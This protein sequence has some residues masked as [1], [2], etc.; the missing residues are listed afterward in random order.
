MSTFNP[1]EWVERPLPA[2]SQANNIL[3]DKV[4]NGAETNIFGAYA[5]KLPEIKV[6]NHISKV[7]LIS[8][9]RVR[10]GDN[11]RPLYDLG[12][13]DKSGFLQPISDSRGPNQAATFT[14]VPLDVYAPKFLEKMGKGERMR[15]IKEASSMPISELKDKWF[16]TSQGYRDNLERIYEEQKKAPTL[17]KAQNDERFQCA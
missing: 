5:T 10:Y 15:R 11:G 4:Q 12:Y 2:V 6:G 7:Y 9:P 13:I 14:P 16:F 3:N 17:E 1:E 8:G